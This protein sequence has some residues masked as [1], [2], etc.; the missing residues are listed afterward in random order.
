MWQLEGK[1]Y[2]DRLNI[3]DEDP[4]ACNVVYIPELCLAAPIRTSESMIDVTCPTWTSHRPA[5]QRTNTR[6]QWKPSP[7]RRTRIVRFAWHP[8]AIVPMNPNCWSV[9][10]RITCICSMQPKR[11][12][13]LLLYIT[14]QFNIYHLELSWIILNHLAFAGY[15]CQANDGQISAGHNTKSTTDRQWYAAGT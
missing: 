5:V 8:S 9:I 10:R 15:R 14:I 13:L 6:C 12:V 4:T 2:L 3:L 7:F 1:F 11:C